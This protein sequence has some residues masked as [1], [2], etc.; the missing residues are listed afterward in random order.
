MEEEEER[1]S[2]NFELLSLV[3]VNGCNVRPLN[4]FALA[5]II[6]GDRR[7]RSAAA[8]V[9]VLKTEKWRTYPFSL[10]VERGS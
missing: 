3:S 1:H 10:F 5:N 6:A 7:R 8:T 9:C 4:M 2:L